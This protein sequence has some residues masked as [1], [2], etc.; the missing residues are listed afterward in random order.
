ME[1][2]PWAGH[3]GIK[4]LPKIIPIIEKSQSLLLFT[5]TR[6]QTEIWYQKI[7]ETKPEWA[8]T[9]A[10]HHGSLDPQVRAWVETALH[11]KS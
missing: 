1:K 9:M 6:S 11:E 8:G 3:L 7:L 2:Y 5:N 10:M 4:L